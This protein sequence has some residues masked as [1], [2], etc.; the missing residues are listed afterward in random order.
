MNT[1]PFKTDWQVMNYKIYI[2]MKMTQRKNSTG[3][4]PYSLRIEKWEIFWTTSSQKLSKLKTD[5]NSMCYDWISQLLRSA[6]QLN[7]VV[8]EWHSDSYEIELAVENEMFPVYVCVYL[9]ILMFLGNSS[10]TRGLKHML[11]IYILHLSLP[12][13]PCRPSVA[14]L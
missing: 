13:W 5:E 4:Y 1:A 12:A 2:E 10:S 9:C 8:S 6:I 3:P 14:G 11:E 7:F